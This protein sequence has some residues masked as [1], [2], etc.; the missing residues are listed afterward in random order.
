MINSDLAQHCRYYPDGFEQNAVAYFYEKKWLALNGDYPLKEY[1][2]C[3]LDSFSSS[4]GVP[5]TLKAILL[6]RFLVSNGYYAHT[7]EMFKL[8]YENYYL[9]SNINI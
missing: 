1:S 7:I 5:K 4:D 9:R 8:W 2:E 6:N 3:G